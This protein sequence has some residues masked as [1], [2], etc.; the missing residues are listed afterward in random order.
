VL[1]CKKDVFAVKHMVLEVPNV[2]V[3]KLMMSLKS[4]GYVAEKYNWCY[5][6]YTLTDEGIEY[7]REYLHVPEDT[8]PA[9]LKKSA[10]VQPPRTFGNAPSGG[11]RP[12]G[13]GYRG[14]EGG[15][16]RGRRGGGRGGGSSRG[17]D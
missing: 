16:F 14:G 2:H 1:V 13:D 3:M 11:G 4:R 6:Y 15:G 17:R 5:L 9:T 7:L 12:G 10:T 8:V